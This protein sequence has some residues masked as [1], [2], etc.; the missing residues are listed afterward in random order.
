MQPSICWGCSQIRD[1]CRCQHPDV[2]VLTVGTQEPPLCAVDPEFDAIVVS[3]ETIPG[4]HAINKVQKGGGRWEAVLSRP[5]KPAPCAV[6]QD[7]WLW[8]VQHTWSCAALQTSCKASSLPSTTSHVTLPT[9][10]LQAGAC[11]ARLPAACDRGDWPDLLAPPRRQAVF[12]GPAGGGCGRARR[13]PAAACA[14]AVRCRAATNWC[15]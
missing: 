1:Y 7:G 6:M 4:A 3:E 13:Q 15:C 14:V 5:C 8:A 12:H 2:L 11:G 9:P 10:P